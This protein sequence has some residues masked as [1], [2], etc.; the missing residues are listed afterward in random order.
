MY[1]AP[2]FQTPLLYFQ[3]DVLK[4]QPQFLGFLEL[5]GGIGGLA[6]ALV[7]AYYCRRFPL[8]VLLTAGII[9]NVISTIF[10]LGYN[11]RNTAMAIELASGFVATLAALPLMDI[12][13]RATPKG[14]ESFGYALMMSVRNL[15]LI[16]FSDVLGSWLLDHF[17]L[18]FKQLVWVNAGSTALVLLAI[19]FLPRILMSQH[20]N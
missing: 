14:S 13:A 12:A 20:D 15:T 17:H 11:S 1:L 19:P 16:G 3:T 9:L 2:G 4:L 18:Q 7:Y 5:L 10:Y 8:R 6:G